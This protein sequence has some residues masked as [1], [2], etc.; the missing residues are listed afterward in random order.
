MENEKYSRGLEILNSIDP[1]AGDRTKAI[2]GEIAPDM[3]NYLM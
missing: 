1:D 2:L 3:V